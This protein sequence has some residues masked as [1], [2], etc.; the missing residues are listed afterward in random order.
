MAIS[1]RFS[2]ASTTYDSV[3]DVQ[4]VCAE[5]LCDMIVENSKFQPMKIIDL[6]AGT[7]YVS[8]KLLQ[9][10]SMSDY[11][12]NDIAPNMLEVCKKR[13]ANCKRVEYLLADMEWI[14]ISGYDIVA[15]NLAFQWANDLEALLQKCV[16]G[17]NK[18]I[19]FSTLLD[20]TFQEWYNLTGQCGKRFPTYSELYD[21][22]SSFGYEFYTYTIEIP[23]AFGTALLFAR[24]IRALGASYSSVPHIN[25][26][27]VLRA[28]SSSIRSSY[29]VFFGV[30]VKRAA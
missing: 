16:L 23:I 21:L 13:F 8:Q 1:S 11:I 9:H 24:Y 14:D 20:G 29:R 17:N 22:C 7:G 2:R 18:I 27:K 5:V 4:A 12:L 26:R 3:A 28:Y 19:A 6:G 30:I 25:L 15:S 10:Y